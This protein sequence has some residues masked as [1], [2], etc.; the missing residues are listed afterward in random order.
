MS[1]K[2]ELHFRPEDP[3]SHPAFGE[4]RPCNNLLLKISKKKTSQPCNGQ[5]SEVFDQ[6]FKH[7]LHDATDVGNVPEVHEFENDSVVARKEVDMQKSED[8]VNLFADIVARVSEAYHFDGQ[9][10]IVCYCDMLIDS[11]VYLHY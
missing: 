2:L 7:P 3:Y 9:N 1:N 10:S 6:T 4:V 11:F 8:Q 5:S